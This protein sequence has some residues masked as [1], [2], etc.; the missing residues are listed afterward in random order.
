M[1]ATLA[2]S[3]SCLLWPLTGT[4]FFSLFAAGVFDADASQ[5]DVYEVVGRERVARVTEGFNV[6][7]LAYGQ[8]GSGKT[9]TSRDARLVPRAFFA[10]H[11]PGAP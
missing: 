6:C 4:A 2:H 9:H 10:A 3:S 5:E 7:I 1:S 8:T 11:M